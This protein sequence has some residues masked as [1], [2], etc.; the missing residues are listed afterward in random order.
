MSLDFN[1]L[2]RESFPKQLNGWNAKPDVLWYSGNLNLL[3]RPMISVVGSRS[4]SPDGLVRARRIT[5]TLISKGICVVS[6]LAEGIDAVAH[7]TALKGKGSTIA[8]MGTPINECYPS[9]H[10]SLKSQIEK[11]GLVLSQFAPHSKIQ[12]GNFPRRNELMAALSMMTIVV[13]ANIDSGTRHQVKSSIALGHAVG[14]L[15]SLVESG[16][17]W[18]E[19]AMKSGLGF[20]IYSPK[21][22]LNCIEH[23]SLSQA[24]IIPTINTNQL[25]L[26][27]QD[28]SPETINPNPEKIVASEV[29]SHSET[30]PQTTPQSTILQEIIYA[31]KDRHANQYK[32]VECCSKDFKRFN[33][34]QNG[35]RVGY[36]NYRF[37]GDEVLYIDDLHIEAKSIRPPWFSINLLFW[38]GSFPPECWR[39][40]N[41]QNRGLGTA[42]IN[43]LI[44]YARAKAVKRI[45]GEMK[46]HDFKNNKD[47][48]N[49]YRR[50]GF[51]VVMGDMK[52]G[53]VGKVSLKL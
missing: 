30:I 35:L 16:F 31:I 21:D 48:S 41:Y 17:P 49:W 37:E 47:L 24:R 28:E 26:F 9:S 40:T 53:A 52:T 13:E 10:D 11:N 43:F 22:L 8:V 19:E 51:S 45:E 3:A 34:E 14:F 27:S 5:R 33:I 6:G 15:P 46:H 44:G 50:R 20:A 36:V 2:A 38:I 1:I 23:I 12:R 18:V 32:V 7:N 25:K 42:M 29:V 4:A 39:V